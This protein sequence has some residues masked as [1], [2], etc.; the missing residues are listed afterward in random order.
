M[1]PRDEE[2]LRQTNSDLTDAAR[3]F[4]LEKAHFTA[5]T[6]ALFDVLERIGDIA[7]SDENGQR[8]KEGYGKADKNAK[9]Y[10]HAMEDAYQGIADRLRLMAVSVDLANW[11]TMAA[12]PKVP[13]KG[14]GFSSGDGTMT[15]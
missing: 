8:F 5:D 9:S 12:L 2:E 13:D 14:P 10:V 7:G 1:A 4:D 15:A 11:S 3:F 6:D